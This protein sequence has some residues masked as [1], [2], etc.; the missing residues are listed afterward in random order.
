MGYFNYHAKVKEL[1]KLGKLVDF[2]FTDKYKNISPA[3]VLVFNNCS[4]PVMPIRAHRFKEYLPI[5]EEWCKKNNKE[6]NI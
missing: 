4:H 1:I 6:K 2:Y 3:L 5:L